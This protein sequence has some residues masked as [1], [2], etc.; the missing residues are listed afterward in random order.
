[1][2]HCPAYDAPICSLCCSLD[3]RCGDLP[4]PTD[5]WMQAQ[6]AVAR[7]LPG[8]TAA[9]IGAPLGRYLA[10]MLT[11]CAVIGLILGIVHAGADDRPPGD[12]KSAS[13]A[14]R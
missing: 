10:V 4:S 12:R 1:M 5:A 9:W 11:L 6:A 14:R 8:R 2:A 13:C 7:I 3:A